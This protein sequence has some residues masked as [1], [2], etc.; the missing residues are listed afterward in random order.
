MRDVAV[1]SVSNHKIGT[2]TTKIYRH[3]N[4]LTK[5]HTQTIRSMATIN[6][7]IITNF[8]IVTVLNFL[9]VLKLVTNAITPVIEGDLVFNLLSAA[10]FNLKQE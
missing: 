1:I 4:R 3:T 5:R 2:I 6:Y 10:K 7:Y 8:Y 9:S